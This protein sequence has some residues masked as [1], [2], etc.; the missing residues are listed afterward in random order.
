MTMATYLDGT[1][2]TSFAIVGMEAAMTALDTNLTTG[3]ER[4]IILNA[5]KQ[6]FCCPASGIRQTG[7]LQ[8][9]K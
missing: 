3:T 9:E 8:I 7:T 5:D 6:W 4:G 1:R 2:T